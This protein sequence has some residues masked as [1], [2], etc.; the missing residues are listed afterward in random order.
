MCSICG[1]AAK[2]QDLPDV[3]WVIDML[4]AT[5]HRGPD[6]C[7]LLAGQAVLHAKTPESLGSRV[8][9]DTRAARILL[10]QSR[11]A[12]VGTANARQPF[13]S[14]DGQ[15]A[16]AHNGEVYNHHEL[17]QALG[18]GVTV[19]TGCDSEALMRVVEAHYAA[20]G[21][22]LAEAMRRTLG[23][24]TGMYA[25]A[26]TDG[27][28]LVLARD[29]IGKKPL[30]YVDG[31]DYLAFASER[32]ALVDVARDQDALILRI[33]PGDMLVLEQ[34]GAT[35]VETFAK[36]D[37]PPIDIVEFEEAV[38]VYEAA[39]NTAMKRRT[40]DL[41]RA[42]VF[43]SGGVD[44]V[45]VARLLQNCG[46]DVTGYVSGVEGSS[47]VKYAVE[48]A[49]EMG[50][51]VKVAPVTEAT[52]PD[53][54]PAILK[55]AEL[56]GPLMAE[57]S[58]PM[59][60]AAK[61]AHEDGHRVIFTGQAADEVWAGYDWYREVYAQE[62]PLTLHARMWEDVL[63][64]PL[65]TLERE[66]RISMAWSLECRAPFLDPDVIHA[67]MRVIPQLKISDGDD[68][69]RKHPHRVLAL[70]L[71]V[72]RRVAYREKIPAQDGADVHTLLERA[73]EAR[74]PGV[75]PQV[76]VP[77]FGSLYRYCYTFESYST[78]KVR[79]MLAAIAAEH[80]FVVAELDGSASAPPATAPKPT[81]VK[82]VVASVET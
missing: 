74:F 46:V 28:S 64:L 38:A 80:G 67:A 29:P 5:R 48:V 1:I 6:G 40:R 34:D 11:L 27:R 13:L 69:F 12:I 60:Y 10:A 70:R 81:R 49:E 66:D 51:T 42:A 33:A 18:D 78:P 20:T 61:A 59:W 47:D 57:V 24:L 65:D 44:S 75:V 79:A 43:F 8:Q 2:G 26:V 50:L 55:A 41:K 4:W 14:E 52:L 16:L 37:P 56:N 21:G 31:A 82:S 19:E 25:I 17:V 73:A 63:A 58:L 35:R 39:L 30:Y 45:M 3:A 36:L 68:Q 15:L 32:K 7:G 72:P 23:S 76:D 9:R 54:L 62:G 22:D 77:D 53:E 71:G